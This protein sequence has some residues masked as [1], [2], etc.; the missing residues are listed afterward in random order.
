MFFCALNLSD[1]LKNSTAPNSIIKLYACRP[2]VS[3][4]K[5]T[6]RHSVNH[7]LGVLL[8]R[9]IGRY[10]IPATGAYPIKKTEC[11]VNIPLPSKRNLQ[12]KQSIKAKKIS[13]ATL[14]H[15]FQLLVY[16]NNRKRIPIP[17]KPY[18]VVERS[19]PEK[20]IDGFSS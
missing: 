20:T 10:A 6:I 14:S 13:P 18:W 12:D 1:S 5:A 19:R 4:S 9:L 17:H 15:F 7:N 11:A 8:I 2:I 16:A 3:V